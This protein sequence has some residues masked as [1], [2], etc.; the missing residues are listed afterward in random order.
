MMPTCPVC[1]GCE[2]SSL[3]G[4]WVIQEECELRDRFGEA[5]RPHP[6]SPDQLKDLTNFFHGGE[7]EIAVCSQCSLLLRRELKPAE[8]P[9]YSGEHYDREAIEAVYPQYLSAFRAKEHP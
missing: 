6:I 7:A 2:F 8:A 1:S 9:S 4:A 5:R 3:I